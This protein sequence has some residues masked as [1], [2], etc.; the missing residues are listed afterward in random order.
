MI[1]EREKERLNAS[2]EEKS[3]ERLMEIDPS[4]WEV[5]D[6]GRFEEVFQRSAANHSREGREC[7]LHSMRLRVEETSA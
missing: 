7:R 1:L 2:T 6:R 3:R 4:V 5:C